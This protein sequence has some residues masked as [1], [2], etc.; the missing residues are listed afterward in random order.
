MSRPTFATKTPA[1]LRAFRLLT[2][3]QMVHLESL[4]ISMTASTAKRQAIEALDLTHASGGASVTI[5]ELIN[6]LRDLAGQSLRLI[7]AE[8]PTRPLAQPAEAGR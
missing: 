6:G 8:A 1:Q 7:D 5:E 2:L 3:A 4:G